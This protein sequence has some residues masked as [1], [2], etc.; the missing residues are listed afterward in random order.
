MRERVFIIGNRIGKENPFPQPTHRDHF[1]LNDKK[2]KMPD[3]FENI[4]GGDLKPWVT[5]E[6][7]LY[8]LKDIPISYDPIKLT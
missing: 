1:P 7:T 8:D 6:E 5:A 2:V 3:M 4:K